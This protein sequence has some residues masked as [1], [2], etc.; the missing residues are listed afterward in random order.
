MQEAY[1]VNGNMKGIEFTIWITEK[2]E[3]L[4]EESPMGFLLVK[5]TKDDALRIARP[6]LDLL[7]QAA[8][9]FKM[10][11]P[12]DISYLKVRITGIS[13]KGL[14]LDG[15]RQKLT[16]DV[17]EINKEVLD[18]RL[19]TQNTEIRERAFDEYLNDTIFIQSKDPQ[20]KGLAKEIIKNEKDPLVAARLIY[21]WVYKNIEKVPTITHPD[22]H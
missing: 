15:G 11:L 5:E 12:P 2:G 21:D 14:D 17:L 22:G 20:I 3:V 18:T 6:S 19:K 7:S 13:F 9:P 4:R 10:K 16:G 8:V 1:K